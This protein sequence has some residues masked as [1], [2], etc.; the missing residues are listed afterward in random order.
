MTCIEVQSLITR[1]ID[2][3]LDDEQL[4]KFIKHIKQCPECRDELEVY[5]TLIVGMHQLDNNKKLSSNFEEEL[6]TKLKLHEER[7]RGH[8]RH[9]IQIKFG[10]SFVVTILLAT[11]LSILF[12]MLFPWKTSVNEEEKSKHPYLKS[13]HYFYYPEDY[14]L[15]NPY[16]NIQ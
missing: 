10:I 9:M 1:F 5:Y 2:D 15:R 14:K 8:K 4:T 6:N 12:F 7:I 13:K 11:V 3:T 16:S